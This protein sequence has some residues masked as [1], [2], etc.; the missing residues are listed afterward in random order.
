[1]NTVGITE[2]IEKPTLT[3]SSMQTENVD[4]DE[5]EVQTENKTIPRTDRHI[6]TELEMDC[7]CIQ[8]DN[9]MED[10]LD[11]NR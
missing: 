8:T 9:S 11:T 3:E 7:K 4:I 6:Q 10:K 2:E 1:M 5:K